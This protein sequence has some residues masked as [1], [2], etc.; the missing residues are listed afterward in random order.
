MIE[1]PATPEQ[2]VE[3]GYK[4]WMAQQLT[5]RYSANNMCAIGHILVVG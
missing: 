3:A 1:V 2:R 5:K 4:V